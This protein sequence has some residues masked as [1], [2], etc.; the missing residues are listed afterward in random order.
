MVER[1][2]V[3]TGGP[4]IERWYG[5]FLPWPITPSPA[6]IRLRSISHLYSCSLVRC[7]W[8]GKR[9]SIVVTQ[10]RRLAATSLAR[11]VA[12]LQGE[13]LG[14]TVRFR[15]TTPYHFKLR[16]MCHESGV[17]LCVFA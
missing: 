5:W 2:L 6:L 13:K 8:L 15:Y 12:S 4:A 10:P 14:H 17:C 11:R 1:Q 3:S 7:V 16:T 9:C